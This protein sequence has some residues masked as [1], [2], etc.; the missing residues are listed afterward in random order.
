MTDLLGGPRI[1]AMVGW[2]GLPLTSLRPLQKRLPAHFPGTA[3]FN[4]VIEYA[5]WKV[6]VLFGRKVPIWILF[7]SSG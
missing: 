7:T 5:L 4:P 2:L 6:Q 1:S 3:R